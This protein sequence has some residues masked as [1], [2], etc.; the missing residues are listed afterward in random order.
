M[1]SLKEWLI[2]AC[3]ELGV[4]IEPEFV[5]MASNGQ[6]LRPVVRI[7]DIGALNGMLIF[8]NYDEVRACIDEIIHSGYGYSILDQPRSDEEF[9]LTAFREMFADWGLDVNE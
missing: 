1:N 8:D 7:P 4:K 6:I 9:E 5:W 2:R 3:T